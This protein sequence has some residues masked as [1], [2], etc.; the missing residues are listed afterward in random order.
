LVTIISV[1][2]DASA[3]TVSGSTGKCFGDATSIM[4]MPTCM[5]HSKIMAKQLKTSY[6][7]VA[8]IKVNGP[9]MHWAKTVSGVA[10]N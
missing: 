8:D 6:L 5:T 2:Q 10:D 7:K 3:K 9:H 4:H 1:I